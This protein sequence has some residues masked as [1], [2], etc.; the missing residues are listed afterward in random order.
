MK[1]YYQSLDLP[2]VHMFLLH[3]EGMAGLPRLG[4]TGKTNNSKS[5][6]ISN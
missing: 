6:V 3:R 4:N 5:I 1:H 2:V